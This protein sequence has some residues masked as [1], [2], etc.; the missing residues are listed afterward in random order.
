MS[1]TMIRTV[2]AF[3]L[4]I[5]PSIYCTQSWAGAFQ[6]GAEKAL[7]HFKPKVE[8]KSAPEEKTWRE[9]TE[10]KAGDAGQEF[11]RKVFEDCYKRASGQDPCGKEPE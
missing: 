7:E 2:V 10:D 8:E 4:A 1:K 5:A 6:E 11:G 9:K 3:A